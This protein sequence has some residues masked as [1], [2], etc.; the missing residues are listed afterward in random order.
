MTA[1]ETKKHILPE[2]NDCSEAENNLV[3]HN[4]D[5][6]TFDYVIEAI[7]EICGHDYLQASQCTIIT[8]Y[9]G[10]CDIKHGSVP[11][12]MKMK[13]AFNERE[14]TTTID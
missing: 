10:K 14:L 5:V 11:G 2:Q 8:H 4:D 1:K 6:H 3:L 9:K 12:L 13:A 7:M